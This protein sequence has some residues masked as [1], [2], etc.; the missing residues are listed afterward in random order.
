MSVQLDLDPVLAALFDAHFI[1]AARPAGPAG[2]TYAHC[3]QCFGV[4]EVG[5]RGVVSDEA[6]LV[7][8]A[9]HREMC[10]LT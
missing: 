1:R 7:Y 3:L 10:P 2:E 4:V 6:R 5:P 8:A 9:R